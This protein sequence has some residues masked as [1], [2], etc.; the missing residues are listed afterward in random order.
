[1]F[2][3]LGFCRKVLLAPAALEALGMDSSAVLFQGC[4]I[5]KVQGATAAG[6]LARM[7]RVRMGVQASLVSE[8]VSTLVAKKLGESAHVEVWHFI[9]CEVLCTPC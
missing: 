1:M 2:I 3:Q 6:H 8:A 5:S 7:H 9:V 4:L